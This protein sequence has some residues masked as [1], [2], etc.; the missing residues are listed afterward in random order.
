VMIKVFRYS[1]I[2]SQ[3][4]LNTIRWPKR[5]IGLVDHAI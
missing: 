4:W 3:T 5:S 1:H 2:P